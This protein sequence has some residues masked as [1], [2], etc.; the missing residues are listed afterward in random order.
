MS[1]DHVITACENP[2]IPWGYS[3]QTSSA[4]RARFRFRFPVTDEGKEHQRF[5][6][7]FFFSN[8]TSAIK[9]IVSQKRGHKSEAFNSN[10]N[11]GSIL[12]TRHGNNV[13]R[14]FW[15][16]TPNRSHIHLLFLCPNLKVPSCVLIS[17][18]WPFPCGDLQCYLPV[19]HNHKAVVGMAI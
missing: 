19:M 1:V 2:Q 15:Y 12:C 6:F 9:N 17:L 3:L 11:H 14:Q 13:A 18:R 5:F 8:S 16:A 10:T 4:E 7:F